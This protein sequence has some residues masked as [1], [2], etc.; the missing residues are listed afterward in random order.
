MNSTGA[1]RQHFFRMF[2]FMRPYLPLYLVGTFFFTAQEFMIPFVLGFFANLVMAAILAQS[3]TGLYQAVIIKLAMLAFVILLVSP[4]LYFH[5][6]NSAKAMRELKAQLFRAFVR[7]NLES[8][9]ATHSGEGIAAINTDAD[10]AGLIYQD[11]LSQFLRCVFGLSLSAIVVFIVDFRLGL[12]ALASGFLAFFA[13]YALAGPL[14]RLGK[15]QL[16]ANADSVKAMSNIFAGAM[17]I[18]AFNDQERSLISFDRVNGRLKFIGFKDAFLRTWQ[19]LFT[20]IQGWFTLVLVFALGG[21][22]VATGQLYFPALMLVFP[23]CVTIAE[24]ISRLGS[25]W[26][27][28]QAPIAAAKRVGLDGSAKKCF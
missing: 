8:A 21:W 4:G 13:Q 26:A 28:L 24:S 14:A 6:V 7:N 3:L 12:G 1:N 16:D 25:T 5:L 20:T 22:L 19:N 15:Q 17:A 9:N 23:L 2:T 11:A 18:R 27:G 10:T